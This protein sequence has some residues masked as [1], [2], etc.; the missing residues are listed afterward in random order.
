MEI[1]KKTQK[2]SEK[3]KIA[4]IMEKKKNIKHIEVIIAI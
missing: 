2:N 1:V 3:P 4:G